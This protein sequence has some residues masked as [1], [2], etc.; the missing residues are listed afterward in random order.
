MS[1][2]L[3]G[4]A[5]VVIVPSRSPAVCA[6]NP[7]RSFTRYARSWPAEAR[8]LLVTDEPGPVARDAVVLLGKLAAGR[9]FRGIGGSRPRQRTLGR[10]EGGQICHVGVGEIR[11]EGRHLRILAPPVAIL[12][13][14]PVGEEGRLSGERWR[15]RD[16][17]VAVRAVARLAR[18]GPSAPGFEVGGARGRDGRHRQSGGNDRGAGECLES[19]QRW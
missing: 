18:L 8:N 13:Q 12:D 2:S 5:A 6:L 9:G 3:S 14:L 17:R 19:L 4:W 16:R 10:V 15:P 1:A 11:G 7:R